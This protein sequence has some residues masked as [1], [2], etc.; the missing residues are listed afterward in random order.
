MLCNV[1]QAAA[2]ERLRGPSGPQGRSPVGRLMW[3]RH[4]LPLCFALLVSLLNPP[5]YPQPPARDIRNVTYGTDD[6]FPLPDYDSLTQWRARRGQLRQQILFA[7][8]LWPMLERPALR[9]LVTGQSEW[10]GVVIENVALETLPGFYLGGNL[11]RPAAPR[12]RYPAV[13]KPHGHWQNGRLEHQP[14]C[15]TPTLG[16]NLARQGYVVFA[17]DM[18]GYNDT[19]QLPHRFTGEHEQLWLFS[20]LG[21]QLWNSIRVV[22]YLQSLAY[23]DPD[24]IAVTGASGG[25]TQSFLLAAVD[26]RVK[27]VAPVNMVSAIMQGG[28]VCENAPGLRYQTSNVEIAALAAPRPMLL[29]ASTQDWTRNTLEE[30]YPAIRRIYALYQQEPNVEA[31]RFDAPHNYNAD[32][33]RAVYRFFARHLLHQPDA[34]VEEEPLPPDLQLETLRVFP[35]GQLPAGAKTYSELFAWWQETTRRQMD[36]ASPGELRQALRLALEAS[37]PETVELAQEGDHVVLYRPGQGDRVPGLWFPGKGKPC[38]LVHPEGSE[39]A[40][41]TAW[42]ARL[43]QQQRPVLLLDT[44]QTGLA[45]APR[46]RSKRHFLSFN[47]TEGQCRVQDI[48][49]GLRFLS[50]RSGSSAIEL[51]GLEDAAVWALFA[52]ALSPV[53]IELKTPLTGFRGEDDELIRSFFVPGIQRAGG[54]AAAKRL[55]EGH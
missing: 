16:Y 7:A 12:K 34:V 11:Y 6:H 21:L 41:Q 48:L 49:T 8:G 46:D 37:W 20:P 27:V 25:G 17:Y 32:S 33:R 55:L 30:E 9:V 43:R 31:V 1:V 53:P 3:K 52:A 19:A 28:C 23:V 26:E 13:L 15:S 2:P 29:V 10:N 35:G 5:V 18:V 40:R 36:Q 47:L 42:F 45:S 54:L 50:N 14:L 44:F 24:Q 22:D 38:L 51:I 39:A 4:I